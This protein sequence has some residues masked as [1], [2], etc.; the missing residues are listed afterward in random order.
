MITATKSKGLNLVDFTRICIWSSYFLTFCCSDQS[1]LLFLNSYNFFILVYLIK[2]LGLQI[3]KFGILCCHGRY[4]NADVEEV[5]S[6]KL[7]PCRNYFTRLLCSIGNSWTSSSCGNITDFKSDSTRI[8]D[9]TRK[10]QLI[11]N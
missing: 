8:L 1:L 10:V 5:K 2:Q 7:P 6:P 3:D 11:I 4:A 9:P